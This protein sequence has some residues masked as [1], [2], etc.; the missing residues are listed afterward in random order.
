L[1]EVYAYPNPAIDEVSIGSAGQI[2]EIIWFDLN[3]KRCSP[4]V[5]SRN[6]NETVF[7]TNSLQPGVYAV[8]VV[9]GNERTNCL[10]VAIE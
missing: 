7:A 2:H 1:E 4:Q 10:R 6:A 3:G 8:L 9:A 5:I